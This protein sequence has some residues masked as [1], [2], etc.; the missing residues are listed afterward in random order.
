MKGKYLVNTND[1]FTGPD[2]NEYKAAWG[3]C[4]VIST[5]ESLGFDPNRNSANWFV[6]VGTDE[7]H[8]LIAGCQIHYVIKCNDKPNTLFGKG[9]STEGGEVKVLTIPTRIFIP[10]DNEENQ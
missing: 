1:W 2:G 8:I 10:T 6:K 7:N 3:D 4:E 5:K 9:W